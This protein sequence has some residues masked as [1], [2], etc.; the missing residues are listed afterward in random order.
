MLIY[1]NFLNALY[2]GIFKGESRDVYRIKS[3]T[4]QELDLNKAYYDEEELHPKK[5][6]EPNVMDLLKIYLPK[7]F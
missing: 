5:K 1:E 6:M 3:Y 7:Y 4:A 2:M